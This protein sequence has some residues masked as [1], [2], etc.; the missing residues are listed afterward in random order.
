MVLK[1]NLSVKTP[2]HK[3]SMEAAHSRLSV[4]EQFIQSQKSNLEG[5]ECA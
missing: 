3:P 4:N 2:W 1:I 5:R